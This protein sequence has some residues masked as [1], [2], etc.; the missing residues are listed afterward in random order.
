M[1]EARRRRSQPNILFILTDQQ[2][3]DAVAALGCPSYRTP[4]LD[5]LAGEGTAFVNAYTPSPVCVPAR[6]SLMYSQYPNKTGCYE[7]GFPMPTDGRPSFVDALTRAGYRTHGVGKCHFTPDPDALRGF[8]T[9]LSQEHREPMPTAHDDYLKE[10]A[11]HGHTDFGG[12][13]GDYGGNKYV[14]TL[15]NVPDRLHPSRWVADHSIR[16]LEAAAVGKDPWFLFSSFFHP[17][18]PCAP[19]RSWLDTVAKDCIPP[20]FVPPESDV[21]MVRIN[22]DQNAAWYREDEVD[23]ER[24]RRHYHALVAYVDHEIGRILAALEAS[25]QAENTLVL[26]TSD[27]G[28]YLGDY[29]SFGKRGMHDVS[30]RVPLVLRY[31]DLFPRGQRCEHMASLVDIGPT[32]LSLAGAETAMVDVDGVSLVDILRGE[33]RRDTIL[34]Q[35]NADARACVM[36]VN[37]DWKYTLSMGDGPREFLFNRRDDPH[38][39]VNL[40][41]SEGATLA[42]MRA[43]L[44]RQG[45]QVPQKGGGG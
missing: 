24:L 45:I 25:G 13:Y 34:S 7:N 6:C 36:A 2:R 22:R 35:H 8:Q 17:H 15:P 28:E 37:A 3:A 12:A 39:C 44:V 40:A 41:G 33:S 26:F 18:P 30:S 21:F 27:H 11:C 5:R 14:P 43:H 20:P 42:R 9:R 19:P 31:P 38:D 29:R 16:F 10:L 32:L 23:V 1:T 4:H